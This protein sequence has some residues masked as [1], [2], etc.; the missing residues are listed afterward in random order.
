MVVQFVLYIN[1]VA[2]IRIHNGQDVYQSSCEPVSLLAVG[3]RSNIKNHVLNVPAVFG[4]LHGAAGG[5]VFH[6]VNALHM[7]PEGFLE[8]SN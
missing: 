5:V 4:N 2:H 6:T 3:K 7:L 8:I 1:L